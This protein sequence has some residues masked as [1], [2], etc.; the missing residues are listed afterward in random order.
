[1]TL[2]Y[3]LLLATLV[4]V[5]GRSIRARARPSASAPPPVDDAVLERI[6]TDGVVT[7]DED[8]P[9]D[10]QEIEE[11]EERFWSESWDEPDEPF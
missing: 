4:V 9:L 5:A 6:L 8:E 10:L 3:W 11:E 2:L 1:M 7:T